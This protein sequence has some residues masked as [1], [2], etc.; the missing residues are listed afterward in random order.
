MTQHHEA[1]RLSADAPDR[2]ERS[3]RLYM[4]GAM[5]VAGTIGY[6]VLLSDQS[7]FNVVFWRCAIGS[8]GLA[9]YCWWKGFFKSPGLDKRQFLNLVLGG[10]TLVFNWYF[11]FTAYQLT[12]VGIT[13][14]AYNSQ[15]F[16]LLL[17]GFFFRKEKPG[18]FALIC[19]VTAFA[20]LVVLA[21]PVSGYATNGY[22]L[23]IAS[24]LS[25]AVLYAATTLLTKSLSATMRPELIAVWHMVIGACAFALLADFHQLPQ[26]PH[27]IFAILALGLFH[28][29]FMYILLYGAFKKAATGSLAILGFIYPLVAVLV[30]YLAYDIVMDEYQAVGA[31]LILIAASAY[32]AG[33]QALLDLSRVL[34]TKLL[35]SGRQGRKN[36]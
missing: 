19:L 21:K 4:A 14:V 34:S 10:L 25:A 11:L 18:A 32:A 20:G 33:P 16:L 35:Q 27:H 28:T 29:T 1:P 5:V 2:D 8:V 9:L 31:A 17:A 7:P 6:F 12:S 24:A 30:D 23:G 26:L 15:P 22:L 36:S 13:T 3:G